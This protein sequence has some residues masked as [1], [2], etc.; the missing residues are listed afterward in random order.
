[1]NSGVGEN[2]WPQV[3]DFKVAIRGYHKIHISNVEC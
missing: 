2:K 1:M 3:G